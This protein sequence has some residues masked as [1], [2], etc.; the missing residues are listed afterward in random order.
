MQR[1]FL[2]WE[3]RLHASLLANIC[4][5]Y[6]SKLLALCPYNQHGK[7]NELLTLPQTRATGMEET[8]SPYP[9]NRCLH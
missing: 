2:I 4:Q 3:M 8:I 5:H 6:D 9:P 7:Q 1:S